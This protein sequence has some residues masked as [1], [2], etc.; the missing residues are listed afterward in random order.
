MRFNIEGFPAATND[1]G[2]ETN[3]GGLHPGYYPNTPTRTTLCYRGDLCSQRLPNVRNPYFRLRLPVII[4]RVQRGEA[5][6]VLNPSNLGEY[7]KFAREDPDRLTA[8]LPSPPVKKSRA[9]RMKIDYIAL[10]AQCE[11][12]LLDVICASTAEV[13]RHVVVGYC[14]AD[15]GIG[16]LVWRSYS[17]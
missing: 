6:L 3:A 11:Q 9:D 10:R 5:K 7:L 17:S 12:L 15:H 16:S 1:R 14:G 8:F 13:A 4:H 2:R